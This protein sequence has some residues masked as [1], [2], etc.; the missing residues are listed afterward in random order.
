MAELDPRRRSAGTEL[1][2]RVPLHWPD[3]REFR[4]LSIDGGG[5]RGILPAS[6]LAALEERYLAGRSVADCF[7]LIT[8]TSTGGILALGL[9]AGMTARQLRDLY[10]TR[11]GEIFPDHCWPMRKFL[12]WKHYLFTRCDRRA[13]DRLIAEIL[14]EKQLW[15]ARKR[16]CIPSIDATYGEVFVFK[17][18]HH[19]SFKKDWLKPMATVARATSAA[20][21]FFKPVKDETEIYTYLD[22]GIWANNPVMIGLVDALSAFDVS[23]EH[24]KILSLGCVENTYKIR[25]YH[26][27]LGGK[28]LWPKNVIDGAMH[29]QSM[30][31]VG[32]A[33][34]LIGRD[35]LLRV[36]YPPIRP[37]L[38]LH[39]WARCRELLPAKASELMS[40]FG[41]KAAEM[42][43]YSAADA[44]QP[45]Y[46]PSSPPP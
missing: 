31:A 13:L 14:G 12:D 15:E 34:L 29:L 46:T 25:W 21:S 9:A 43:L 27:R 11:G 39:D 35:R 3:E 24:V 40:Q 16:L 32:Q 22:G 2:R 5:I 8:G 44:Y 18:P 19:P 28:L 36:N 41:D 38:E 23:R 42:F 37:A 17:T 1:T 6:F 26:R 20:Q 4:I 7:D 10:M 30:N 45:I 33:G